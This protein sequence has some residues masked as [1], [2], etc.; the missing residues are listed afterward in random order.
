MRVRNSKKIEQTFDTLFELTLMHK[1]SRS[2]KKL[3][4]NSRRRRFASA[5][6]SEQLHT[7]APGSSYG[8]E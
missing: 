6:P 1:I 8:F 4:S 3:E 7:G 5:F 2:K